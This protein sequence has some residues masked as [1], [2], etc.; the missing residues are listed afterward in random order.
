[1]KGQWRNDGCKQERT[2]RKK[3][4]DKELEP[5]TKGR[6]ARQ[7][8]LAAARPGGAGSGS[9]PPA[10]QSRDV[11]GMVGNAATSSWDDSTDLQVVESL[12]HLVNEGY[13]Q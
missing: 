6:K 4:A 10:P 8:G 3:Q 5:E 9:R 11:L 13:L 1:M 12:V 2:K 7:R